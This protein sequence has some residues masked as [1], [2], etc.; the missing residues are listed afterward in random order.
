MVID[1][2]SQK[3]SFISISDWLGSVENTE[4]ETAGYSPFNTESE[5]DVSTFQSE[6]LNYN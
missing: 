2:R 4:E 5:R 6:V 3:K 1:E